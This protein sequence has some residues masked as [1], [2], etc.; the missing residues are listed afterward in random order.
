MKPAV[1]S[2]SVAARALPGWVC[3]AAYLAVGL[4]VILVQ[5]E[6][7]PVLWYPPL[8]IGMA[9]LA[10][11]GNRWAAG[12]FA[13]ELVISLT[14]YGGVVA[15]GL[16]I[17]A[18]ATMEGVLGAWVIRAV[19]PTGRIRGASDYLRLL[20]GAGVLT[21]LALAAV[22]TALIRLVDPVSPF[23]TTLSAVQWWV[24]DA[25]GVIVLLPIILLWRQDHAPAAA[26]SLASWGELIVLHAVAAASTAW[27]FVSPW[28]L[29]SV[30]FEWQRVVCLLPVIWAAVRLAPGM[31]S[32]VILNIA[33]VA[34]FATWIVLP[35]LG[36]M[37]PPLDLLGTQVFMIVCAV[38][39]LGLAF[40]LEGERIAAAGARAAS[41][42]ESA[43]SARLD[44]LMTSA[45][46][47]IYSCAAEPPFA[48]E[49]LSGGSERVFGFRPE[50]FL[51]D[52][53][54]WVE[55]LHPED[56]ERVLQGV[57]DLMRAGGGVHE[58]RYLHRDGHY[59]WIRDELSVV[60]QEGRAVLVGHCID[61]TEV[62]HAEQ[63]VRTS[64]AK[65][66]AFMGNSP[67]GAWITDL[68]GRFVYASPTMAR[69]FDGADPT[70]KLL[71]EVLPASLAATGR[72]DCERV[73]ATGAVH[74]FVYTLPRPEGGEVTLLVYK[75]PVTIGEGQTVVGGV[76]VDITDRERDAEAL[77]LAERRAQ[78]ASQAKSEFL[79]NMSH[80][81]RTPL[82]A[83]LGFADL[84]G[85]SDLTEAERRD[86]V[87]T[88]RRNGEHLLSVIN[89]IL[90]L[91]KIEAERLVLECFT[92]EPVQLVS[93]VV[94]LMQ[95]RAKARGIAL[96]WHASTDAPRV[97][98]TDPVRLRQILMNLVGNAIKFTPAGSVSIS[99]ASDAGGARFEVRDTGIGMSPE[100]I[101]RLFRPFE[102]GDASMARVFGGAGLGLRISQRLAHMLGGAIRVQSDPGQ[103]SVFT[104]HLP[105]RGC[106][107]ATVAT[108]VAPASTETTALQN[109]RVLLVEDGSDTQRLL[110]HY[111]THA[112]AVLVSK[113]NG[114]EGLSAMG[115]SDDPHQ[116]PT[117]DLIITDLQMPV[118]DGFE[119]VT[120][121]RA[122][123]V[124]TP[125]LALT[126]HTM[127]GDETRA[128]AAGC[129][130]F[131]SKPVD[132][133]R[134]L[135]LCHELILSVRR[136]RAV[137][138]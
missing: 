120:R 46:A 112:G 136:T 48:A 133:S 84:L 2:H 114:L 12:V 107:G 51:R 92:V 103:G 123:G 130:A 64:E 31:A 37:T 3:L 5:A 21:P 70:G 76:C 116:T 110:R 85:E 56:R 10:R 33:S 41:R 61:V 138:T 71:E 105:I 69:L 99:F 38:G 7:G 49:F 126:A 104:L 66:Q 89:D 39:G 54:K 117:F 82:T 24:G 18:A 106:A 1:E 73:L 97:M 121:L 135:S 43:A 91:S 52:P 98:D 90:D 30:V 40:A 77:R 80:E 17:A 20:L 108:G 4:L 32:T 42:R 19:L 15:P 59:R 6:S 96:H 11:H 55:R 50:E 68:A 83:I 65:F 62:R 44:F 35:R 101:S 125:V 87:E 67:L 74:H 34:A 132:R 118:M 109:A 13:C 86:H 93:E 8:A 75:F 78:A 16:I 23:G 28:A 72:K 94:E 122:A 102:Q 47:A 88:V 53:S 129:D 29:G 128:L 111:F 81:L 127:I 95:V 14:Q 100:Q 119:F 124:K 9:L 45:P 57:P 27:A 113:S 22:G 79:A 36:A 25:T 137:T 131:A 115:L 60:R 58:Y 134:L 63:V 26:G